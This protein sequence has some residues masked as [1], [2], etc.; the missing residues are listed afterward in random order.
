M[1]TLAAAIV[2]V[3]GKLA[4]D[5]HPLVALVVLMLAVLPATSAARSAGRTDVI[6]AEQAGQ[7]SMS[8]VGLA[9]RM[10]VGA[11]ASGLAVMGASAYT[12][13]T[14]INLKAARLLG[15]PWRRAVTVQAHQPMTSPP[16]SSKAQ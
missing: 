15:A 16:P 5:L 10:P 13:L 1:A 9:S 12:S 8:I 4:F 6:P 3:T 2:I 14:L 11:M 7:V